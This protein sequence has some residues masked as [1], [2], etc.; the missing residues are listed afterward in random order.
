LVGNLQDVKFLL[1]E[2]V[3]AVM[4]L[5]PE[6]YLALSR[7]YPL[8]RQAVA[9]HLINDACFTNAAYSLSTGL[10]EIVPI[11]NIPMNVAD[12]IILTKNQI[13]L[14]YKLGLALGMST[15]IQTYVTTFGG[16]LG[17]GFFW[18]QLAHMLVGLI[19]AWGII[20]KVGVAYAGTF[21]VGNVVL[22]WYQT[23]KHI[24]KSQMRQLYSQAFGRGKQ[25]A[26]KLRSDRS[27]K[28]V[29]RKKKSRPALPAPQ[30]E[31]VC[32]QCG[33]HNASDASYCQYCG[34][35]LVQEIQELP[36]GG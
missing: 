16:V 20:P 33:K 27:Q 31:R 2:F 34:S 17:A 19:P 8:F 3:P 7:H 4:R 5:L 13:F 6:Y 32:A 25:L 14:A 35:Q 21:V 22:R 9:H 30:A 1:A 29:K 10:I 18:R 24:S 36:A 26:A 15:Q 28:R 12:V 11:L 23:G